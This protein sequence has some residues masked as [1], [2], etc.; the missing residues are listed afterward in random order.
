MSGFMMTY[1]GIPS[2]YN[3]D[4][5]EDKEPLFDAVDTLAGCIQISTG[6]LS[7]LTIN[8]IKMKAALSIEMLAT[9][10]AEYL[11]RKGV[12]F[13]ETHHISGHAVRMAEERGVGMDQ[14]TLEDFKSLHFAFEADVAQVWD[15]ER[16][17][18]QR[19]SVGGTSK[20][21]VLFQIKQLREF[22]SQ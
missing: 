6:V 14:L 16:S 15:F 5:Q 2:T 3:K 13:R 8:P 10:L 12:P 19:S 1:K 20:S 4:L 11:V 7:T 21:S 9:D 18:E 22:L 17:I